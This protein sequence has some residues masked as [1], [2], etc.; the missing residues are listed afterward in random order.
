MDVFVL[1]YF[2]LGKSVSHSGPQQLCLQNGNN[3]ILPCRICGV[4]ASGV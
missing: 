4:G 1:N 2:C 3:N